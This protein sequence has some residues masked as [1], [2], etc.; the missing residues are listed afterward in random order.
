M[1]AITCCNQNAGNERLF[2][3]GYQ[4]IIKKLPDWDFVQSSLHLFGERHIANWFNVDKVDPYVI[5]VNFCWAYTVFPKKYSGFIL[6][7]SRVD[8]GFSTKGT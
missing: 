1:Q 5:E 6:M 7:P 4:L 3:L 8:P 2:C